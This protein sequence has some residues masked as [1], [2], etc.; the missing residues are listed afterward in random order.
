MEFDEPKALILAIQSRT[1][2][3]HG[4]MK[5]LFGK[6]VASLVEGE[7]EWI[8]FAAAHLESLVEL[9]LSDVEIVLK[10][11]NREYWETRQWS[12]LRY[13]ILA[14]AS[15]I[16]VA[17]RTDRFEADTKGNQQFSVI[18]VVHPGFSVLIYSKA[19]D[20]VSGDWAESTYHNSLLWSI[21]ADVR[22]KSIPAHIISRGLPILWRLALSKLLERPHNVLSFMDEEL[23]SCL[24]LGWF[25]DATVGRFAQNGEAELSFGSGGSGGY[26]LRN[27]RA[28][29]AIPASG[30]PV[31][32]W[33]DTDEPLDEPWGRAT[34]NLA[35]GDELVLASDGVRDQFRERDGGFDACLAPY[36]AEPSQMTL[37]QAIMDALTDE[38]KD[39]VQADDITV[40][41]ICRSQEKFTHATQ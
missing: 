15:R 35:D 37:R 31:G 3:V 23:R 36:L 20:Y 39:A 29:E 38:L 27:S 18:S 26:L 2:G 8:G 22:G 1:P 9:V 10:S 30:R 14:I 33:V 32:I 28:L 24:P 5:R 21:V 34:V 11:E 7:R 17:V 16:L 19:H 25:V 13:Y 41:S 40:M 4:D 12:E 6:I